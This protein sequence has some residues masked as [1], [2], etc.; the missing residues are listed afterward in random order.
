MDKRRDK[1]ILRNLNDYQNI[2]LARISYLDIDL[3]KLEQIKNIKG[4][5]SVVDLELCLKKPDRMYLGD[6]NVLGDIAKRI[7]GREEQEAL[8]KVKQ[9]DAELLSEIVNAG[10]GNLKIISVQREGLSGLEA[11]CFEDEEGTRGFSFR[12]TDLKS[13]STLLKD[14]RTD[15]VSYFIG[16]NTFQVRDAIKMFEEYGNKKGRNRLYGHS[17]GGNIIENIYANFYNNVEHVFSVNPFHIDQSI[18]EYDDR[19][20]IAFNNSKYECVVTGGDVI[21]MLNRDTLYADRVRYVQNNGIKDEKTKLIFAHMTECAKYDKY[22]NFVETTREKAY[23]GFENESINAAIKIVGA[24]K[25]KGVSAIK[26]GRRFRD[27]FVEYKNES[28]SIWDK[29]KAKLLKI[30]DVFKSKTVIK[31]K[32][33][34]TRT[35]DINKRSFDESLLLENWI[36]E[37]PYSKEK[38]SRVKRELKK[39]TKGF[40][41]NNQCGNLNDSH[42]DEMI[43]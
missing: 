18:L 22:G 2:L 12:G 23:K 35:E 20:R 5:V 1:I 25:D 8:S 39:I 15:I 28:E 14:L 27:D 6:I 34:F 42:D 33:D 30:V 36:T 4:E 10:M 29:I 41:I 19:I 40:S 26:I 9:T 24:I 17:L 7:S 43:L 13:I 32:N 16:G 11:I 37:I 38:S 31:R 21:S 3:R